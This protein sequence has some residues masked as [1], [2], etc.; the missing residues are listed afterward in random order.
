MKVGDLVRSC[1]N[2]RH[3][4]LGYGLV[5]EEKSNTE[6][7]KVFWL[8]YESNGINPRWHQTYYLEKAK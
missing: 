3:Q 2:K 5:I 6:S 8:G 1:S 7:V 4:T